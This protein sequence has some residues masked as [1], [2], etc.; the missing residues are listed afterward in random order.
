MCSQFTEFS[1][2]IL[3]S[4][5]HVHIKFRYNVNFP[6]Y[7]LHPE[8][9]LTN[10]NVGTRLRGCVCPHSER[11]LLFFC[12][13]A[14]A[15]A[16]LCASAFVCVRLCVSACIHVFRCVCLCPCLHVCVCICV[17]LCSSVYRTLNVQTCSDAN[18][19]LRLDVS[20]VQG[21]SDVLLIIVH[22]EML[23]ADIEKFDTIQ[24]HSQFHLLCS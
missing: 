18:G 10:S 9:P 17:H 13:A 3:P 16:H 19:S 1:V 12:L 14:S 21:L 7:I 22:S 24:F 4:I 23:M 15:C 5:T 11:S 2:P 8:S 6:P 20:F